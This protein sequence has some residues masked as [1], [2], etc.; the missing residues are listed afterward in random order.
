MRLP[1]REAVVTRAPSVVAVAIVLFVA[2]LYGF[3]IFG[4]WAYGQWLR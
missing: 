3:V 2:S 1:V 4:G